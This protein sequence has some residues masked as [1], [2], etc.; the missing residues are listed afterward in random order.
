M[1]ILLLAYACEPAKGSEP[2]VGWM[3]CRLLAHFG[4]VTVITRANNRPAIESAPSVPEGPKIHFEYVDL[5]Q[6][7]RRWKRGRQRIRL[8]YVLWLLAAL[9]KAR[10]LNAVEKFDLAWH[11]TLANVWL[12]STL[13]SLSTPFVLGPVSGG[14]RSC[15]RISIVG[16]RGVGREVGRSA[17]RTIAR[18]FNPLGRVSWKRAALILTNNEDTSRW[19]PRRYREKAKVFPNVV[20]E[21]DPTELHTRTKATHRAM[22]AGE[23]LP[24][25]AVSL[26]IHALTHL[27]QWTLDIY[28]DGFD[29]ARLEKIARRAGVADR[30]L[31][32]GWIPREELFSAMTE[33]A[34]VFL[35]PSLHDEVGWV[36][37]EA[38]AHGLPVVCLDRGGPRSL[39]GTAVR[40]GSL[41]E[42]AALIAEQ[43][44]LAVAGVPRDWDL[45]TRSELLR[46]ILEERG[47]VSSYND[48]TTENVRHRQQT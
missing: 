11:V 35:F 37:A 48:H 16:M 2:G 8:Y 15:W 40:L 6:W 21:I 13:G 24:L 33:K 26:A 22:F 17:I 27:P 46:S 5:P 31:F 4:E 19:L 42:T 12:G 20:L 25:K 43:A 10:A 39:G 38:L 41:K 14:V 29:R 34:D 18:Y 45:A 9:R 1:R 30:V 32:H 28:G 23:L 47:L 36:V 44:Q 7:V 3:W